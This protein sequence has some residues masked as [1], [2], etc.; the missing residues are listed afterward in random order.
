MQD[1]QC[2]SG[3]REYILSLFEGSGNSR[4]EAVL[5]SV[6]MLSSFC[7]FCTTGDGS[8]GNDQG[9]SVSCLIMLAVRGNL[10]MLAAFLK[11]HEVW[12]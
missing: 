12:M 4:K 8:R 2:R 10:I 7:I 1:P 3:D 11:Y 5:E 6:G 9:V